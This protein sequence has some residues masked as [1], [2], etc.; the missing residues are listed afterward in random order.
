MKYNHD[1]GY[2]EAYA[3]DKGAGFCNGVVTIEGYTE[4][5]HIHHFE[6]KGDF[7]C[8][9]EAHGTKTHSELDACF[10]NPWSSDKDPDFELPTLN[11][12]KNAVFAS[13][14]SAGSA[15]S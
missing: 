15:Y 9:P 10:C 5:V 8:D 6:A 4:K 1:M 3:Y 12:D 7:K 11:I 2:L 14:F 13:G